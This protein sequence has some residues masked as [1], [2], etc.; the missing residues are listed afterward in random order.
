MSDADELDNEEMDEDEDGWDEEDEDEE[1]E[2]EEWEDDPAGEGQQ[3]AEDLYEV[4]SWL[5]DWDNQQMTLDQARDLIGDRLPEWAQSELEEAWNAL[6]AG[7]VRLNAVV[8][9]MLDVL[10]DQA[11]EEGWR[12]PDRQRQNSL[13]ILWS[14]AEEDTEEADTEED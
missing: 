13:G 4:Q 1:D 9:K 7:Q 14:S 11:D 5:A 8:T 2:D 6:H 3:L 10:A 12:L